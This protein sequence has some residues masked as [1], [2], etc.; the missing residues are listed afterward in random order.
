MTL[1]PAG[2]CWKLHKMHPGED[3]FMGDVED[4]NHRDPFQSYGTGSVVP[5]GKI[6]HSCFLNI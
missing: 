6:R 2:L 3:V 1:I 5:E 4:V